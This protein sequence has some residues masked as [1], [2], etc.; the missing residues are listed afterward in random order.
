NIIDGHGG[1]V[2]QTATITITGANDA[3]VNTV[4][5][6]QT[7]GSNTATAITGVAVADVDR[8][9]VT[10][11]LSVSS[12]KLTV[13]TEGGFTVNNNGTNTVTISGTLAQVNAAL[14]TLSYLSNTNYSGADTLTVV[15]SD[16]LASD[17]D[18]VAITVNPPTNQAPE[19]PAFAF[20]PGAVSGDD[21]NKLLLGTLLGT[22][23]AGD[24]NAGD[25]VT[26]SFAGGT[27]NGLSLNA[28][29]GELVVST[30]L[31]GADKMFSVVATDSAGNQSTSTGVRLWIGTS[32]VNSVSFIDNSETIIAFGLNQ[33]DTITATGGSGD[34]IFVGGAGNDALSG[35]GGNDWLIGGTGNDTLNG[36]AGRDLVDGGAGNNTLA[37]GAGDDTFVFRNIGS[38]TNHVADFDAGTSSTTADMLR[39][40]VGTGAN[41]FSLGNNNTTVENF[42]AGNNATINFARTEIA[43][44][45]DASV[46]DGGSTSFQNAINS[47]TNITTG[48]LFVFHNTD[49]GHAAVYYD[50]KPSA[51]G[52]AVLVAEFDNIKLLGSLGSFNAGDF[53]LI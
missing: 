18:T 8:D 45:T 49:L 26:Y 34:D 24:P 48:A 53:L 17:M 7:V 11:T 37:G 15:T 5:D 42:K 21:G 33:V 4:P 28:A 32:G 31:N 9:N 38:T 39:F 20:N 47:Y 51:A 43:V 27:P 13:G 35:G 52:G 50:S 12:G 25:T 41:E 29:T 1:A 22:F 6:S 19:A 44:K 16:G 40:D 14:V 2:A 30:D 36:G 46:T 10:T 3:P 23:S